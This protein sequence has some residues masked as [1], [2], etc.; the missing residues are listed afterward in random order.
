VHLNNAQLNSL[1]P[2]SFDKVVEAVKTAEKEHK[3]DIVQ[4]RSLTATKERLLNGEKPSSVQNQFAAMVKNVRRQKRTAAC[5]KADD[6]TQGEVPVSMSTSLV[7]D[8][9]SEVKGSTQHSHLSEEKAEW[10]VVLSEKL[11]M[12]FYFNTK[13]LMGQ[14]AVPP[15]FQS[16]EDNDETQHDSIGTAPSDKAGVV[17]GIADTSLDSGNEGGGRDY[18]YDLRYEDEDVVPGSYPT[19]SSHGL[20]RRRSKANDEVKQDDDSIPF[21][22]SVPTQIATPQGICYYI[23]LII[24]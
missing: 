18:N 19:L 24:E 7:D 20:K 13:T 11:N 3:Q 9:V 4:A 10:R 16:E 17:E 2:L 23:V 6:S 5:M 15:C 1:T 12:P 22:Y 8:H 21:Q 14:F